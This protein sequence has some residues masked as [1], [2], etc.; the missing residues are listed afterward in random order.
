MEIGE[1][2]RTNNPLA[3]PFVPFVG[4]S[5]IKYSL[6]HSQTDVQSGSGPEVKKRPRDKLAT[7]KNAIAYFNGANPYG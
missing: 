3:I 1:S 2:A 5:P 4:I 6:V 7:L